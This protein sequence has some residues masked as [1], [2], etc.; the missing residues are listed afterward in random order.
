MQRCVQDRPEAVNETRDLTPPPLWAPGPGNGSAPLLQFLPLHP[1]QL[2][3]HPFVRN[4]RFLLRCSR[5]RN[6]NIIVSAFFFA[7]NRFSEEARW[8]W[9]NILAIR[10]QSLALVDYSNIG[11]PTLIL[12]C[13]SCRRI[14]VS[15]DYLSNF[16]SCVKPCSKEAIM[17]EVS[18]CQW[19]CD[20]TQKFLLGH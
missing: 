18:R 20:W 8:L 19:F 3:T 11:L 9:L 10:H 1:L 7:L 5:T 16:V 4:T 15:Q 2:A 6:A 12:L 14:N 13:I 17:K